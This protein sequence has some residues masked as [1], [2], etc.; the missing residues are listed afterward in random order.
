MSATAMIK[1][2]IESSLMYLSTKW[3]V[4]SE[5]SGWGS[6]DRIQKTEY[7]NTIR[8]KHSTERP[9]TRR[10]KKNEST[11]EQYYVVN[12]M[13]I[14]NLEKFTTQKEHYRYDIMMRTRSLWIPNVRL[15]YTGR[16]KTL[17]LFN[18]VA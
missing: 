7:Q 13:L 10:P 1:N 11:H 8:P 17:H 4:T 18:N 5:T 9:K 6:L 14:E 12:D 2:P 3:F 16:L 15:G